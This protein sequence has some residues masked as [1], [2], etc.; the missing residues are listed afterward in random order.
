MT[1]EVVR[2]SPQTGF[3]RCGHIHRS[4]KAAEKCR[5]RLNKHAQIKWRVA[6]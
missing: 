2:S 6:S 5:D 4:K 3:Q 1:Y